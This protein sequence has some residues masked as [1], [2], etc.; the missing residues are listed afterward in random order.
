MQ[1]AQQMKRLQSLNI[2]TLKILGG[3]KFY[4]DIYIKIDNMNNTDF[5]F[6]LALLEVYVFLGYLYYV[7]GKN[8]LK[9]L[10]K[11]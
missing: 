4:T 8:G 9:T 5:E 7:V 10:K 6:K 1:D 11:G 3:K 2:G